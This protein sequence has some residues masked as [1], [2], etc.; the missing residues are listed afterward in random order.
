[1]SRTT[2]VPATWTC[3]QYSSTCL[4]A[5]MTTELAGPKTRFLP[6]VLCAYGG[7]HSPDGIADRGFC[8]PHSTWVC[9]SSSPWEP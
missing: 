3:V 2:A 6:F 1:M 8:Q 4:E 7:D 9:S 5:F